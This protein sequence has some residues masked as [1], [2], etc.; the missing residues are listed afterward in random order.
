MAARMRRSHQD[1][2]RAKIQVSNL[3]TRLQKYAD[4]ELSDDDISPNRLN[5]IK[6]LLNKALPDLQSIDIGNTD[7]EGFLFRT[8]PGDVEL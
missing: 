7:P 2:V 8:A 1:D 4:G 6:I 3:I 5:V